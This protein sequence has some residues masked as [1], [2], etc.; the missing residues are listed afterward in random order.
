[1]H[2]SPFA[3]ETGGN[4]FLSRITDACPL[5]TNP[6]R[7]VCT[8]SRIRAFIRKIALSQGLPHDPSP[9][10]IGTYQKFLE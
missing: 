6:V 1:S 3:S 5:L 9:E 2:F 7:I 8:T 10:A 4:A